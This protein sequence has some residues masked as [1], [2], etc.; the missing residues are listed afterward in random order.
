MPSPKPLEIKLENHPQDLI[1]QLTHIY[2]A[3]FKPPPYNKTTAESQTFSIGFDNILKRDDF[4][5][6]VAWDKDRPIGFAYGYHLNPD[7]GWHKVLGPPLTKAGH[8]HWL[9]DAYCLAEMA[10]IPGYWGR[11]IG[12]GLHDALFE[13]VSSTHQLLSTMQDDSTNGYQMYIKRGWI[14]LLENYWVSQVDRMYRVMGR[15]PA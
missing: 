12:G 9:N 13:N 5:L 7:Y 4:R 1:R 6:Y 14:N 8:G 10:V 3:A 2:S 11:G 15:L